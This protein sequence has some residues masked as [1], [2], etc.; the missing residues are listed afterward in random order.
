MPMN[1]DNILQV[2]EDDR[3]RFMRKNNMKI[4]AVKKM[5]VDL[6]AKFSSLML[7][8]M[9]K[10]NPKQIVF[11]DEVNNKSM[12]ENLH[13]TIGHCKEEY[14]IINLRTK[15]KHP[16]DVKAGW[17]LP[18]GLLV[19]VLILHALIYVT[20]CFKDWE[21]AN[22]A[23]EKVL[24][25]AFSKYLESAI[26]PKSRIYCMTDHNFFSTITCSNKKFE[27]FVIQ[28]GLVMDKSYYYPIIADHFLAWG[29]RSK[30]QLDND[31]KVIVAGTYKFEK[32]KKTEDT[33]AEKSIAYCVSLVN[34][35]VV[36]NKIRALYEVSKKLNFKLKV[37]MHP[38]SLFSNERYEAEFANTDIEFYKECS[39]SDMTF[40]CA[41]IENST[42]LLDLQAMGKPFMIFDDIN[43]YFSLY[44]DDLPW[45]S[46]E[47]HLEEAIH[48]LFRLEDNNLKG[49]CVQNELNGG[50]CEIF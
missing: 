18:V 4:P 17:L 5:N 1:F 20:M 30:E 9:G 43:G 48:D 40:S 8:S 39:L 16:A 34:T 27:T 41:V 24:I 38:G 46:D 23:S 31:P 28:H 14:G 25:R 33:S 36:T 29:E 26:A 45:I 12:Y 37:K 3:F 13:A 15:G 47:Q 21:S 44:A 42:I 7:K 49:K 6:L 2:C 10:K 22:R 35:Q 11:V 19:K 50:V 32:L